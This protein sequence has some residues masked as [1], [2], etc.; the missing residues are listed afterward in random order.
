MSTIVQKVGGTGGKAFSLSGTE[1]GAALNKIRVWMSY[2][3]MLSVKVWL[4]DG[5]AQVFGTSHGPHKEFQFGGGEKFT[6][7]TLWRSRDG[8]HV[9][10]I[11]FKTNQ[12]REFS[13]KVVDSQ[14][15]PEV[16]MD[17]GSGICLGV[18]GT[19]Y[20]DLNSLGFI[21]LQAIQYS[22]VTGVKYPTLPGAVPRVEMEEKKTMT[23][24]ND[25]GDVQEYRMDVTAKYTKRSDWSM[26][27]GIH[28]TF[29]FK[30]KAA[31]PELEKDGAAYRLVLGPEAFRT[32]SSEETSA[33]T[34]T[35]MV[36]VAPGKTKHVTA[37]LGM[38]VVQLPYDAV[39]E[40]NF[41]GGAK[42]EISIRGTYTGHLYTDM[43]FTE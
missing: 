9:G 24:E 39:L 27:H 40:I 12:D 10:G 22:Q 29:A 16:V 25:S 21:F 18:T 6:S 20:W 14:L 30:V 19:Y 35:E 5:T 41:K 2:D 15:G 32:V 8:G 23:F 33:R 3:R 34:V 36:S 28:E 1:N 42:M 38:A 31:I 26:T 11:H 17:I 43:I 4:T 13:T 37:R 7:L